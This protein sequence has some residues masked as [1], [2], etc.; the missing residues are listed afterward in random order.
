[1]TVWT[2]HGR[3]RRLRSNHSRCRRQATRCTGLGRMGWF[4]TATP[5]WNL[6]GHMR[7][8]RS[9][10]TFIPGLQIC[11]VGNSK[12]C[13]ESSHISAPEDDVPVL[14]G[15]SPWGKPSRQIRRPK[16]GRYHMRP[17]NMINTVLWRAAPYSAPSDRAHPKLSQ[18]QMKM[19]DMPAQISANELATMG[20][21][22]RL[23]TPEP[24]FIGPP[25]NVPCMKKRLSTN[26]VEDTPTHWLTHQGRPRPPYNEWEY[27]GKHQCQHCYPE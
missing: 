27:R 25:G 20:T 16:R 9:V 23:D 24:S 15:N 8:Q 4:P 22:T 18:V 26:L 5:P 10:V 6:R 12:K 7:G 19:S 14:P 13:P 21:Q 17:T 3:C 11:S 2:D 1:M